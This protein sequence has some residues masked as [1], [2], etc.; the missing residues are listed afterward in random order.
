MMIMSCP[1]TIH[2]CHLV[3]MMSIIESEEH[4]LVEISSTLRTDEQ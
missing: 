2:L 4:D 1:W 3:Y